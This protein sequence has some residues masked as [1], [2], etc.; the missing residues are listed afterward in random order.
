MNLDN[1]K[2][3]INSHLVPSNSGD[4]LNDRSRKSLSDE[5]NDY[6]NKQMTIIMNQNEPPVLPQ[7]LR[8]SSH[9]ES[10]RTS[11]PVNMIS[12]SFKKV[13]PIRSPN[14]NSGNRFKKRRQ[15]DAVFG[16][17]SNYD[18]RRSIGYKHS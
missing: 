7:L 13:S 2:K 1:S 8:I 4:D 17:S 6:D 15:L 16:N 9:N 10:N 3:G 11:Q 18:E 5:M 14:S 12:T